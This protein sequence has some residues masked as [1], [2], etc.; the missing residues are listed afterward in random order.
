[1]GASEH[2][3]TPD[4]VRRAMESPATAKVARGGGFDTDRMRPHAGWRAIALGTCPA[5]GEANTLQPGALACPAA[6]SPRVVYD[7][8][9]GAFFLARDPARR[10]V[11]SIDDHGGESGTPVSPPPYPSRSG[12]QARPAARIFCRSC[13]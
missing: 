3:S 8:G 10:Q 13:S 11:L 2:Y 7:V 12:R 9:D 5:R 1:V 6:P 4:L